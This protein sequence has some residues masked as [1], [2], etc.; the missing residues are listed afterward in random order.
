MAAKH[1][2]LRALY[3]WTSRPLIVSAPML[4]AASPALAAAVIL[5]GGIGFLP[6]GNDFAALDASVSATK[7]LLGQRD[8]TLSAPQEKAACAPLGIGFQNWAVDVK[9]AEQIVTKHRPAIV[10]LFAPHHTDDHGVW[11]DKIRQASGGATHVWIQVG[12][13]QEALHAVRVAKPEA[14]VLQ[15]NDAGGHGLRESGSIVSLVPEAADALSAAGHG[16]LP[17]L[18]AGGISDGRGVAAAIA[19]GA[20]GVVMGTRFLASEEAGISQGWKEWLVRA[21]DGGQSTTRSTLPDRLKETRGWPEA[22]DGRSLVG[23]GHHDERSG[24]A[25]EENVRLYKQESRDGDAAWGSHGR[26][27]AYAGTGVGL[28]QDIKPA[29]MIVRE[30][31]KQAAEIL[32]QAAGV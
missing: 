7:Q 27:V 24:T 25:D 1:A 18:A 12:T 9:V 2:A 6:G 4:N 29:A 14:L 11:A 28:I 26:M 16:H 23:K 8:V 31:Q 20:S 5:A 17:L 32:K 15:G 19:L 3:P 13:L 21:A 22:Y 10:W 30:T